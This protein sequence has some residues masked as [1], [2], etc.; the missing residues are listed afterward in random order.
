MR[1]LLFA[2]GTRG[3]VQPFVVLARELISRG[4]E[5]HVAAPPG[6]DDMIAAV[7]AVRHTLP[8]DFQAM[9]NDPEIQSAITSWRG[10]LRAFRTTA[11]I[12]DKQLSSIWR[13]SS[14]I[15]WLSPISF[16]T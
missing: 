7:G 15:F 10:R 1:I 4:H 8:A 6:Y 5:V 13:I 11:D 14:T 2:I 3:D 16:N 12:M 9:V